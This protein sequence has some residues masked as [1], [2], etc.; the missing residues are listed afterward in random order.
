MKKIVI[1]MVFIAAGVIA[2]LGAYEA[3][4]FLRSAKAPD[5]MT[6]TTIQA[7][8]RLKAAGLKLKVKGEQFDPIIPAG[9]IVNQTPAPGG[10]IRPGRAVAVILSKGPAAAR[11][12]S[13]VGGTL[14][15]AESALAADGLAVTKIIKVHTD[16][17]A[18]G[19][20]IAQDPGPAEKPGVPTRLVVSLGAYPAVYY[21]PDFRMLSPDDANALANAIGLQTE[22]SNSGDAVV[23]QKP[24]PGSVITG[25]Q[26]VRL[27]LGEK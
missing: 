20:V 22:F 8:V 7:S 18:A 4:L 27:T 11:M 15:D 6:L 16:S 26:T 23:S 9:G 1:V 25:G 3:A 19:I 12:P 10:R 17:V 5:V 13:V 2:G 21:A 14:A 24:K